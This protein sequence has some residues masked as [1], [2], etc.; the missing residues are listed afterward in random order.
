MDNIPYF[1]LNI[2]SLANV[3]QSTVWQMLFYFDLKFK[4]EW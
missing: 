2:F 1:T 4:T 3:S